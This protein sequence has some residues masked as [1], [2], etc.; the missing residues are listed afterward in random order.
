MVGAK[1]VDAD[2]EDVLDR[3][4]RLGAGRKEARRSEEKQKEGPH[5]AVG[6]TGDQHNGLDPSSIRGG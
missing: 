2:Q 1:G 6:R 4:P 3:R 5:R